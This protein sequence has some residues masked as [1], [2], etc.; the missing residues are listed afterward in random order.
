MSNNMYKTIAE[1]IADVDETDLTSIRTNGDN[2]VNLIT[3]GNY[4]AGGCLQDYNSPTFLDG[5]Y[6]CM[7]TKPSNLKLDPMVLF[8]ITAVP[9]MSSL[10]FVKTLTHEQ[11]DTVCRRVV[12]LKGAQVLGHLAHMKLY[13]TASRDIDIAATYPSK[14]EK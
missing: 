3:A 7:S 13:F 2:L 11:L 12:G 10:D 8:D 14:G 4:I 1:V 6:K 5:L 9:G